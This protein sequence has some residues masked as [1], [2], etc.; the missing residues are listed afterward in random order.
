MLRISTSQI[1]R[2]GVGSILEQQSRVSESSLQL[3]TGKRILNPS[4]DPTGAVQTVELNTAIGSIEQYQ[5]NIVLAEGR[6]EFEETQLQQVGDVLLR[7]RELAIQG[8]N[9]SLTDEDRG[10]IATELHQRLDELVDY[11]NARYANGEYVFAGYQSQTQPFAADG[12][13]GF[14]YSG[15]Q[16]QRL[17]QVSD[18]R[19]IAIADSGFELFMDIPNG[20][21]TFTTQDN[22]ANTGSGV[23]DPG[24]VT[25]PSLWVADTYTIAFLAPDSYEVRDSGGTLLASNANYVSGEAISFAGV[26]TNISGTP[27]AGDSFTLST[28]TSQ[29]MFSTLQNLITALETPSTGA[30]SGARL[31]NSIN[32]FLIDLGQSVEKVFNIRATVGARLHAL[33]SQTDINEGTVLSLKQTLSSVEDLDYAEAISRLQL[34]LV[35]LEAAQ[36]SYV[37]VQGLSLFDFLR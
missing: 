1:F 5:K 36:Q 33:D 14:N 16:G 18:T 32:S 24:S 11:A 31:N 17:L 37:K 9:G 25:D 35:G 8:N 10:F 26:Q 7:V 34:Q 27:A 30:N 21:G 22:P 28:S 15:D 19:Q 4:D 29:D 13:G 20:N 12:A 6:L 23:I 2:Q 3:A